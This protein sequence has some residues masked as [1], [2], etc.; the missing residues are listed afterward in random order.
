MPAD[1]EFVELVRT[2]SI[3]RVRS[4]SFLEQIQIILNAW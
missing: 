2:G 4:L 1:S 3:W